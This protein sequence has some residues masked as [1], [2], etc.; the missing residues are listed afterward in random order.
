LLDV[1]ASEDKL[2]G[3]REALSD[4]A[5]TRHRSVELDFPSAVEELCD[6]L[7]DDRQAATAYPQ[8]WVSLLDDVE[9]AASQCGPMVR[10]ALLSD[11]PRVLDELRTCRAL[12]KGSKRPPNASLRRRIEHAA[13]ALAE[14]LSH[15][16]V[17]VAAFRDLV[18]AEGR[19]C[20][21]ARAGVLVALGAEAG[22]DARWF[23]ARL[24][25]VLGDDALTIAREYE[26]QRPEDV[27]EP[28]G[29]PPEDISPVLNIT[30]GETVLTT[31]ERY[32][33]NDRNVEITA[34]DVDVHPNT[35]RQRLDRFEEATG[36]SLRETET[37][38]EV[39]WALQRRR[40]S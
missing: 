22:H 16:P 5:P 11:Q 39:W 32:L 3:I 12:L 8:H 13:A 27:R 2:S 23:P 30:G 35:V 10:A 19:A 25:R 7:G 31:I 15:G 24:G 20:A 17:L 21:R 29:V 40:L 37:V 33:G 26:L 36:R 14:R 9:W 38:V 6:W 18:N 34:K 1:S 28:A 4:V